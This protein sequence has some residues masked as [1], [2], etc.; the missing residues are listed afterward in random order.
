MWRDEAKQAGISGDWPQIVGVAESASKS[1]GISTSSA[2]DESL[3]YGQWGVPK[4]G[5][6]GQISGQKANDGVGAEDIDN[7]NEFQ[8]E[9]RDFDYP[10]VLLDV[11]DTQPPFRGNAKDTD[12]EQESDADDY[13]D[14]D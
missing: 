13:E 12:D 11:D 7:A 6:W 14:M 10:I 1:E 5:A 9:D 4:T 3:E 2:R 8:F